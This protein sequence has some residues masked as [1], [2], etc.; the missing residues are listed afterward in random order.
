MRPEILRLG[1]FGAYAG[2]QSFD[3]AEL[4]PHRLFLIHGPTGS[5]K[6]T[7]LD[8]ICFAL[9]G[10]SSGDERKAV[11]LRSHH[12]TAESETFVELEFALGQEHYRIRRSPKQTITGARGKP[13]TRNPQ[14]TLWRR[15]ADG[16]FLAL[17]EQ[18]RPVRD[19]I[20]DLLGYSAEEFRQVVLLPQGRFR[21]LLV[22]K[23]DERQAILATL[24]RTALYRRVEEAFRQMERTAEATAAQAQTQRATLLAEAEAATPEAAGEAAAAHAL[25]AETAAAQALL[26]AQ[27]A[28]IASAALAA[29]QQ[30]A[31]RLLAAQKAALL[32]Q[33]QEAE[34]PRIAEE[35]ERLAAARRAL[36]LA[37]EEATAR[38]AAATATQAR[39]AEAEARRK[40]TE[41]KLRLDH[42]RQALGDVAAREALVG[43]AA[44]ELHRLEGLA[45]QAA[46]LAESGK[47]AA[48]AEAALRLA[49]LEHAQRITRRN[50]AAEAARIA[51][52]AH[53]AAKLLADGLEE[54]RAAAARARQHAA[55]LAAQAKAIK[56][57]TTAQAALDGA[58]SEAARTATA[59]MQA[60]EAR[61]AA[62]AGAWAAAAG[63]LA[64]TLKAGEPCLVCGSVHHPAPAHASSASAEDLKLARLREEEC[65]ALERAATTS[66]ARLEAEWRGAIERRDEG[67]ARLAQAGPVA[68]DALASA[69]AALAAAEQAMAALPALAQ[70]LARAEAARLAA[71][72]SLAEQDR[73]VAEAQETS[74]ATAA[75]HAT[76]LESV[77]LEARDPAR[78]DL[79]TRQARTH[80]IALRA[81]LD[82]DRKEDTA[83]EASLVAAEAAAAQAADLAR[84]GMAQAEAAG[85]AF[86]R[87]CQRAGFADLAAHQAARLPAEAISA[88][89][90]GIERFVQQRAI[91]Q[92]EQSR[93]AAEAAGLEQPDLPALLAA[94]A[95]A[96]ASAREA[97]ALEGQALER[98]AQSAALLGRIQAADGTFAEARERLAL[99]ANLSRQTRGMNERRMSFEGFVL[100]SLLDEALAA[101]NAHLSRMLDG[102]YRLARREDPSRANAAVGLDIEVF[103]EW[104]GQPR[105][106]GTLSGGEGFCAALALALGLAETVQAHA[107]ARPVD[108]LL[109]DEGFGSLD[110]DALDKAMEV[111]ANLQGGSRLVGIISHVAELK[112]RIPARLEVTPG[113]R[114]SRAR[115]VVA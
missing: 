114:G 66:L 2:T 88:L 37:G 115:F 3:L 76:R 61:V 4:G 85:D 5:G 113:V 40:A 44:A 33:E 6:T 72:A 87:A 107:G 81:A 7:L 13:V 38:S 32:L 108:T 90:A 74:V 23:P 36:T 111:L 51:T 34:L 10:E 39:E 70:G 17:A 45:A 18:E 95:A 92:A 99:L 31:A 71:E 25:A 69:T 52:T 43:T 30:T 8:A 103:D 59:L 83:A 101:A 112:T 29:G 64:A 50:G 16:N 97:T 49:G 80:A 89:D 82:Q 19:S 20:Q 65:Q 14:V 15:A 56:Q 26:A 93:T 48:D 98:A 57:V 54:R 47:A 41:A 75:A 78:L 68:T 21:E 58:R 77:P 105:P 67:A 62:E 104:T 110:E 55:D 86:L 1:A 63:E 53:Q 96:V 73:R 102:R 9:F 35:R 100:A 22:A 109:I 84:A 28:R 106:S 79:A 12:A 27:A 11:D 42:A 91:A 46:L 60:R 94:E 24:F